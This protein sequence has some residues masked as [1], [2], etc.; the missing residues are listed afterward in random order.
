M[1]GYLLDTNVLS[2]LLRKK[3]ETKVA[4]ALN[5]LPANSI[6]TSSICVMEL[7]RGARRHPQTEGLWDQISSTVLPR[8]Q[9]IGF[10]EQEAVLAG[11]ITADLMEQGDLIGTED[12]QIAATAIAHGLVVSTRNTRH[13]ERVDALKSVSWWD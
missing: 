10:D 7:R 5:I 3:P 12:I 13:F 9:V 4:R 8:V 2:E 11:D 1:S 6:Y